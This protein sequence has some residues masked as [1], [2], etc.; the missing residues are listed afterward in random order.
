MMDAC[1][2]DDDDSLTPEERRARRNHNLV[3]KQYRNRLNAQFERLLAILPADQRTGYDAHHIKGSIKESSNVSLGDKGTGDGKEGETIPE[4][5]R[6]S[7]AEVLDLATRR[8]KTLEQ[9]TR[10]LHRERQELMQSVEMMGNAVAA[11]AG[12]GF[13]VGMGMGRC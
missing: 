5:K 6:M 10:R 12:R 3:E 9:E 7:K 8:I 2:G 1:G 11:R 4:E 13:G